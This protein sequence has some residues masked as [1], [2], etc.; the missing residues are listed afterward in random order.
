MSKP[1]RKLKYSSS[2]ELEFEL[3][4]VTCIR[5]IWLKEYRPLPIEQV[6]GQGHFTCI[7]NKTQWLTEILSG[8]K[9]DDK[10]KDRITSLLLDMRNAAQ[11]SCAQ[12]TPIK[13]APSKR[14]ELDLTSEEESNEE[15][16]SSDVAR[17]A[18]LTGGKLRERQGHVWKTS[19]VELQGQTFRFAYYKRKHYI[20]ASSEN[21]EYFL[22]AARS[23]TDSEVQKR[24]MHRKNS[25]K[26]GDSPEDSNKQCVSW[27]PARDTWKIYYTDADGMPKTS[28]TGLRPITHDP[29]TRKPLDKQS[30]LAEL[31]RTH[32]KA[33][34][35]WNDWDTSDAARLE[36]PAGP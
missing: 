18:S 24:K 11:N 15:D 12:N 27:L 33:I 7:S 5:G 20:E 3:S 19:E 10:T 35:L 28:T 6:D 4:K 21:L 13:R 30:Y 36:I 9:S 32:V 26:T 34:R 23:Y 25:M 2:Q 29:A 22:A 31:H 8:K 1:K 17:N 16:D 14:G